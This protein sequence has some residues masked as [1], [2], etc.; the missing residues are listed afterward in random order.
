M[1]MFQHLFGRDQLER[2]RTQIRAAVDEAWS[3]KARANSTSSP[4]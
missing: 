4:T 1:A 2:L 3:W